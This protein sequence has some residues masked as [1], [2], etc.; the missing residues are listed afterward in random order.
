MVYI[1]EID[2]LREV[3]KKMAQDIKSLGKVVKEIKAVLIQYS[4][5][6]DT[7]QR[8][9]VAGYEVRKKKNKKGKKRKK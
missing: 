1:S 7:T 5:I 3:D 4:N 8:N 6:E 9:L 2:E